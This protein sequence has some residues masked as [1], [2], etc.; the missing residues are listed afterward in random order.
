M[1]VLKHLVKTE[2]QLL[3]LSE[4]GL[5]ILRET[6]NMYFK[7]ILWEQEST[8]EFVPPTYFVFI[9]AGLQLLA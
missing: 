2:T 1:V 6:D 4:L 8:F 7:R 9:L 3:I 5:E